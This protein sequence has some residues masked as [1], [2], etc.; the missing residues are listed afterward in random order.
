MSRLTGIVIE[1]VAAW[2]LKGEKKDYE[3]GRY[4]RGC[5]CLEF[6]GI[7]TQEVQLKAAG[8]CLKLCEIVGVLV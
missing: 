1:N 6:C 2:C 5:G 4:Q 3:Q 7:K 8:K